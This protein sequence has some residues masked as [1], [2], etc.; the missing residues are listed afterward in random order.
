MGVKK[1]ALGP[2]DIIGLLIIIVILV[3]I[4]L[5]VRVLI[6]SYSETKNVSTLYFA[7]AFSFFIGAIVLLLI[8]K[9]TLSLNDTTPN[10][11]MAMIA[12]WTALFALIFSGAA[13]V[14]INM[15]AFHNTFPEKKKILT[16]IIGIIAGIYVFLLCYSIFTSMHLGGTLAAIVSG[17]MTYD[18]LISL[19]SLILLMPCAIS[20]PVVFF[21]FSGMTR[22]TNAP[23]SKRSFWMGFAITLFFVGYIIEVL[24][25]QHI[26]TEYLSIP[27]RLALFFA[28]YILYICFAMPEWFKNRIGWTES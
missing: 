1:M 11:L 17:E 5:C 27:G 10:V 20:P 15:F 2:I 6:K 12:G 9:V 8:E 4:V 13:I 3:V 21:Y 16:P 7:M 22:E 23:N 18:P 14:T 25:I 19:W 28:A 24:P 26:I